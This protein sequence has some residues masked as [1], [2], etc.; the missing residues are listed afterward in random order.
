[1]NLTA[2]LALICGLALTACVLIWNR[3]LAAD[4]RADQ[5]EAALE[6]EKANEKI[7]TKVVKE[8]IRVPGPTV[9]RERIVRLCHQGELPGAGLPAGTP[10]ADPADRPADGAGDLARDLAAARRNHL[11]CA[12]L[13]QA[14]RP[15]VAP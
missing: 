12:G 7:V 6:L 14:V 5:A 9:I 10:G 1:M 8:I 2:L 3:Y 4:T 11:K 15:Q 13:Q